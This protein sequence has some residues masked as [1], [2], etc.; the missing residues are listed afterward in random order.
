MYK[1]ST[2]TFLPDVT[3]GNYSKLILYF[4]ELKSDLVSSLRGQ[5]HANKILEY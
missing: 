5:I 3:E 4:A 2:H 1:G